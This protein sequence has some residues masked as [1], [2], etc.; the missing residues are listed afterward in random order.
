L[1]RNIVGIS[2]EA[3]RLLERQAW[4][5]NI[6]ELSNT[7]ERGVLFAD[8]KILL[9]RHF[10]SLGIAHSTDMTPPP[11]ASPSVRICPLSDIEK[12]HIEQILKISKGNQA[13]AA[14]ILGIHRNTLRKKVQEYGLASQGDDQDPIGS[15]AP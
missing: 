14:E 7:I 4:S 3:I 6:R 11:A 10:T 2:D 5:G 8:G 9:P 13:K 15:L 1:S 12:S